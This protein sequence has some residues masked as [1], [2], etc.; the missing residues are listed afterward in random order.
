MAV[1]YSL[2]P[3]CAEVPVEWVRAFGD[4]IDPPRAFGLIL[5]IQFRDRAP[6]VGVGADGITVYVVTPKATVT[7]VDGVWKRGY[8]HPLGTAFHPIREGA[9]AIIAESQAALAQPRARASGDLETIAGKLARLFV[10]TLNDHVMERYGGIDEENLPGFPCGGYSDSEIEESKR[11][12]TEV[13]RKAACAQ[14]RRLPVNKP[15]AEF[16]DVEGIPVSMNAGVPGLF[17]AAFD[18]D[19][20]RKFPPDSARRNGMPISFHDFV[21]LVRESQTGS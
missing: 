3:R 5:S 4:V 8:H 11:L 13:I 2:A 17:C 10:R 6:L 12:A 16:F 9:E 14:P 20:P 19:P 7:R 18:T 21:A 1:D 15:G